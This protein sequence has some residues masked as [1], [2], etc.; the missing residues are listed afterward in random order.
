MNCVI[1]PTELKVQFAGIGKS[2]EVS[3]GTLPPTPL[4]KV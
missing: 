1:K 4:S 3:F 2:A